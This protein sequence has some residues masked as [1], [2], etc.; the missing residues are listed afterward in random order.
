MPANIVPGPRAATGGATT[1]AVPVCSRIISV[2]IPSSVSPAV[3]RYILLLL[4]LAPARLAAQGKA[5][6]S[7]RAWAAG[8]TSKAIEQAAADEDAWNAE[9]EKRLAP[10]L[11]RLP[12][13]EELGIGLPMETVLLALAGFIPAGWLLHLAPT[14]PGIGP[15]P[16][17]GLLDTLTEHPLARHIRDERFLGDEPCV[18]CGAL[19][20]GDAAFALASLGIPQ[21]VLG[22]LWCSA[23]DA[24]M[25]S[26]QRDPAATPEPDER[27]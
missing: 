26:L 3:V 24:G 13:W 22:R 27:F 14:A 8:T 1:L 20:G 9:T 10:W 19:V 15:G 11:D 4:L 2:V 6:Q 17:L 12:P 5:V 25:M 18:A 16:L 7:P 23:R 21:G